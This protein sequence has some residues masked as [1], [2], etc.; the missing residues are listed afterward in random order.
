M[1]RVKRAEKVIT[2]WIEHKLSNES[3]L[4]VRSIIVIPL[5]TEENITLPTVTGD[6]WEVLF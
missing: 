4:V 5:L 3:G 6:T 2:T 1:D